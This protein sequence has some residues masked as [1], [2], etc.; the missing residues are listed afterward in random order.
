MKNHEER[1]KFLRVLVNN[2]ISASRRA[3]GAWGARALGQILLQNYPE[4]GV[5]KSDILGT[6][7][8]MLH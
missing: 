1:E 8:Q 4:L 3:E 2:L 7:N 6:G 5:L